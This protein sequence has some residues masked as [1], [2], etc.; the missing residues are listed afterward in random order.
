MMERMS[1]EFCVLQAAGWMDAE[2]NHM[3]VKAG[4]GGR[5]REG[6]PAAGCCRG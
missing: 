4:G 2:G 3:Q 6:R 5:R 1:T